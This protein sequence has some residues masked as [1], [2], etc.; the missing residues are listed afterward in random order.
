MQSFEHIKTIEWRT[1]KVLYKWKVDK[2]TNSLGCGSLLETEDDRQICAQFL[3]NMPL[4][5]LHPS[6]ATTVRSKRCGRLEMHIAYTPCALTEI[7]ICVTLL[8]CIYV[9]VYARG[10]VCVSTQWHSQF[11]WH[12]GNVGSEGG[13]HFYAHVHFRSSGQRVK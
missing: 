3:W 13:R 10:Y 1:W 2:C 9:C 11:Y 6:T 12:N 4:S 5:Y 8:F 7:G